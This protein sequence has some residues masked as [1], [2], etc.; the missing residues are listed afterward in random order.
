LLRLVA[1]HADG[2][3]ISWRAEPGS[4]AERA[5]ALER[6]CGEVGRD[7]ATARRSVGLYTLIGENGRDLQARWQALQDWAPGG[8]LDGVSL[9][10]F[11]EDTLTGMPDVALAR[12]AAFAGSGVEEVIVNA[13]HLPFAVHDWSQV[14]LIAS[15]LIPAAHAL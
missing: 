13:A 7:P 6:A 2:W 10:D 12:L 11:A 4:Y 1:L 5:A 3:N 14:E 15:A 9:E 8:S